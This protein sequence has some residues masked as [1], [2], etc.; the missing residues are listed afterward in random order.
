MCVSTSVGMIKK[1]QQ[2]N[3]LHGP[4]GVLTHNAKCQVLK[5]ETELGLGGLG[6]LCDGEG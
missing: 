1:A 3:K 4:G 5:L 6:G 2:A